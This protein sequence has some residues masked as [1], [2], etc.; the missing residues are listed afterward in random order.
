VLHAALLGEQ[1]PLSVA[2]GVAFVA[3]HALAMGVMT[4]SVT[5]NIMTNVTD[6]AGDVF[7][8]VMLLPN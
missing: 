3:V 4:E 5:I 2:Q 1:Q 7:G 6:M 8:C